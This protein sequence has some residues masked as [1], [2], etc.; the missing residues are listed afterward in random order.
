MT[1]YMA[2]E[3]NIA[4]KRDYESFVNKSIYQKYLFFL[5][6]CFSMCQNFLT[7]VLVIS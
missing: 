1:G 7:S 3:I 2:R 6:G 4:T 5:C